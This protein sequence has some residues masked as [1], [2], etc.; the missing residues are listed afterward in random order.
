[1]TL[2]ADAVLP[3]TPPLGTKK[4]KYLTYDTAQGFTVPNTMVGRK[5]EPNVMEFGGTEVNAETVDY[6]L[7]D[8]IPN[9][10]SED[11]GIPR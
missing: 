11:P 1:M 2:I 7:D 3:R 8:I 5:S 6:G 9:D 10:V 4:F